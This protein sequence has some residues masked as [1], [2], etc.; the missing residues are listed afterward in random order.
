SNNMKKTCSSQSLHK[1]KK[2]RPTYPS[3]SSTNLSA[4]RSSY[5]SHTQQLSESLSSKST[6]E[7][8]IHPLKH[9]HSAVFLKNLNLFVPKSDPRRLTTIETIFNN[10]SHEV[11]S[12]LQIKVLFDKWN[13]LGPQHNEKIVDNLI[14]VPSLIRNHYG[15]SKKNHACLKT[16][17]PKVKTCC[18]KEITITLGKNITLFSTSGSEVIQLTKGECSQCDVVH[19]HHCFMVEKEE[20]VH[21]NVFSEIVYLFGDTA[22][23]RETWLLYKCLTCMFNRPSPQQFITLPLLEDLD[24]FL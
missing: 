13:M 3:V 17:N 23:T 15:K 18:E 7:F 4:P 8:F 16:F 6:V 19:Y 22:Y 11:L 24:T 10:N 14:D 5:I 12:R 9:I 21:R 2:K 20:L 1:S